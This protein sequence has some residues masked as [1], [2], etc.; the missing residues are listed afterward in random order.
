MTPPRYKLLCALVSLAALSACG[1]DGGNTNVQDGSVADADPNAPDA[2]PNASDAGPNNCAM[3]QESCGEECVDTDTNENHCGGCTISCEVG[4]SCTLGSCISGVGSLVLSEV[5][6]QDPSYF[7]IYNGGS[8]AV[9]LANHQLQ[10]STDVTS[11]SFTLPTFSL[12][13]GEFLIVQ[14]IGAGL[15]G[16]TLQDRIDSYSQIALRLLSPAGVGLDFVRTGASTVPPPVGT[17]WSA[18]NTG[19]P[20]SVVDQSLVRNVFAP[21]TDTDVDWS[22]VGQS[23]PSAFCPVP[24]RCGDSCFDFNSDSMH[25]GD[26]GISCDANEFCSSGS[27]ITGSTNA[28]ISEYRTIDTPAIEI[29]NPTGS[30]L[31]LVNYRLEVVGAS[32]FN[33]FFTARTLAPGAFL[34]VYAADGVDDESTVFAGPSDAL[35]QDVAITLYDDGGV[36][37]DFVRFG[38]STTPAPADAL[39]FTP[40]VTAPRFFVD[41]SLRRDLDQL[42]THSA[43]D[44]TLSTPSTPGFLCHAGLST[45]DGAC[46]AM[47]V[48]PLHCGSCGNVCGAHETCTAGSCESAGGVVLSELRNQAPERFGLFNGTNAEVDLSGWT[49]EWVADGSSDNFAIPANTVLASGQFVVLWETVGSSTSSEIFMGTP[50]NW[51][52]FIAVSLKDAS[53]MGVDFVRT[54]NSP[55]APPPGTSWTGAAL[56]P[57]DSLSE[58]L[59]R[60][61]FAPDTDSDSDWTISSDALLASYCS[62]GDSVCDQDCIRL[63]NDADHC[64]ACGNTCS[65]SIDTCVAGLCTQEAKLRLSGG[66]GATGRLEILHEGEWGTICDD[67]FSNI[68]A[69]VAC[70]QL[71]YSAGVFMGG[72]GGSGQIWLDDVNC[73]GSESAL[74]QCSNNGWG[75]HNCSHSEDV[76]VT[77]Q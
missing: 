32:T 1:N 9:D 12:A 70:R 24:G 62:A 63:S 23:S 21:D 42:D 58:S 41:E 17:A 54:A 45:C 18:N 67:S 74:I 2:D 47:A 56:N 75:I 34:V 26:C 10:W 77:C 11:A 33:H 73:G 52:T 69:G 30:E 13:P 46:V 28:W 64:G 4:E 8:T 53:G 55:T 72:A 20:S 44:W 29:H 15:D 37:Q 57:S 16:I 49:L 61:V 71:G 68:E 59:L 66:A 5:H 40:N 60:A 38:A 7:E 14:E 43:A 36:S 31:N 6:S 19:N 35:T 76:W 25:C 3:G 51:A 22:L 39:W 50:I 48:N 65:D 27:C